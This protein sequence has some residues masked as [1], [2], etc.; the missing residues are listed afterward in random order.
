MA[1]ALAAVS[2]RFALPD[3]QRTLPL[4]GARGG[5][6]Y[7]VAVLRSLLTRGPLKRLAKGF[8]MVGAML[9]VDVAAMAWTH[10]AKLDS[11]QRRRLLALLVQTRGRRGLLGP[12]ERDE[13]RVLLATLEPRLF[14][15]SAARRLSPVPVPKRLLYGPRGSAARA[16]A[17]K[18]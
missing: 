17:G 16:A 9:A 4:I 13:L 2:A 12:D 11:A 15:G 18:R 5:A 14:V 6:I 10:I 1:E 7:D 3:L 8:P